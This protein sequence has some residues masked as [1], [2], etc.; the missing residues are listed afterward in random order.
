[1][2][3]EVSSRRPNEHG[4]QVNSLN[5]M[6]DNQSGIIGLQEVELSVTNAESITKAKQIE[7][8]YSLKKKAKAFAVSTNDN[9]VKMCLRQLGQPICLFGE[10]PGFRRERL[11][12]Q[13]LEFF[14]REERAPEFR[15][16]S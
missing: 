2:S 1:M 13:I 15:A 8:A 14:L 11:K 10:D 6:R 9:D 16:V 5:R 7:K 4:P 3:S 12:E